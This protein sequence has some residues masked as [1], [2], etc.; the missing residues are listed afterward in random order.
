MYIVIFYVNFGLFISVCVC[1]SVRAPVFG[2]I[3][4]KWGGGG[5]GKWELS[6]YRCYKSGFLYSNMCRVFLLN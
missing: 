3:F 6:A 2:E 1:V 5:E 4:G